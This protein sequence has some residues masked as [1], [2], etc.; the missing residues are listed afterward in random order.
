MCSARLSGQVRCGFQLFRAKS[1][2][3][4][5]C[6]STTKKTGDSVNTSGTEDKATD[7]KKDAEHSAETVAQSQDVSASDIEFAKPLL[8]QSGL[9]RALEMFDRLDAFS[10]KAEEPEVPKPRETFASLLRKSK[11]I[12][13]GDP[14][15]RI[16]VGTIIE[17]NV[18]LVKVVQ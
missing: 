6:M 5:R 15:G 14:S 2:Q 10:E 18:T 4:A 17:V 3:N 16:V 9:K 13:L 12:Q 1:I 7:A 11:L 8:A